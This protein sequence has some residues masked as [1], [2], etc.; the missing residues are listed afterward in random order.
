M[1]AA[2]TYHKRKKEDK[3]VKEIAPIPYEGVDVFPSERKAS[4][5]AQL[6]RALH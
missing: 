4:P 3:K 5:V 1:A 2:P 6:V